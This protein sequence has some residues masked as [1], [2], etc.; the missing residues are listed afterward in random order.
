MNRKHPDNALKIVKITYM[1]FKNLFFLA[2][3]ASFLRAC[4]HGGGGPD[5]KLQTR[6]SNYLATVARLSKLEIFQATGR[7]LE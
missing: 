6:T 5:T 2:S 4:L 3:V 1:F 7:V